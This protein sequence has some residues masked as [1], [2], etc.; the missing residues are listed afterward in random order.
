[1]QVK[2]VTLAWAT[3]NAQARVTVTPPDAQTVK[4]PK[5]PQMVE[6]FAKG[7]KGTNGEEVT[8]VWRVAISYRNIE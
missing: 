6:L 7:Q 5:E 1:M 2:D 8:V 3:K 4:C